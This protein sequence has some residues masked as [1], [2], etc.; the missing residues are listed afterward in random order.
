[1]NLSIGS[2]IK[3]DQV[4]FIPHRQ[5][6]HNMCRATFL[7]YTT[8]H[9]VIRKAFDTVLWLYLN[10]I[11]RLRESSQLYKWDFGPNFLLWVFVN[12]QAYIKYEGYNS[13]HLEIACGMRHVFSGSDLHFALAIEPLV[14]LICAPT[15]YSWHWS[16]WP[17]TS[18]LF[19]HQWFAFISYSTYN[20]DA[21]LTPNIRLI[22]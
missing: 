9:W 6:D 20:L 8:H 7:T 3:K 2:L 5:A 1:M 4:G 16:G 10:Y 17:S 11:L 18:A 13:D 14:A 15:L 22:H 12:L 19:I 21:Q